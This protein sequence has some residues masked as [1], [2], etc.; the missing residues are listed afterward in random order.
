MIKHVS[1]CVRRG[2]SRKFGDRSGHAD[3]EKRR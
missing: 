1:M 3:V 2:T